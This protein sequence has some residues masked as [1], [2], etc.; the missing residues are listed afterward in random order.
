MFAHLLIASLFCAATPQSR[1]GAG[2]PHA[3]FAMDTSTRDANHQTVEAQLRMVKELGFAG[4]AC[5]APEAGAPTLKLMDALGLKL[6]AIYTGADIDKEPP[7]DPRLPEIIR[8][9]KGRDTLV[10]LFVT[11]QKEKSASPAAD[12]K[13]LAAIRR[14]ADLAAESGL[15]VSIY[16]HN[17]FYVASTRDAVR[18]VPKAERKHLSVTF[19]LCHWLK[20]DG[21]K[22]LDAILKAALPHLSVVT[23]N[24]ADNQ[25]DNWDRLIQPLGSGSYDVYELLV[26]LKRLGFKGSIGLQG[27]G[28]KGDVH[29]HLTQAMAV[30]RDFCR[31][32]WQN[33]G[34]SGSTYRVRYLPELKIE[35]D[36]RSDEPEWSRAELEKH[37]AFPW[38]KSPAPPTEFRALCSRD[39][40]YFAFRLQDPDIFVLEKLRDEEDEVFEDRVEIYFSRDDRLKDYYCAE[41]DSR[42]RLFDYHGSYY[43]QID[44]KWNW[45]KLEAKAAA[46]DGGY[47]VEGRIP[48]AAFES[49][50]FP[51]LEPGV[52]IRCG[53]YRAEFS[54]DSSGRPVEQRET[55]HNRGRRIDGPPPLEEWISW[56]DPKTDEPD[57]HIPASFGWLEIVK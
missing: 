25:G 26:K 53:L 6:F 54:H 42:G 52:K 45:P 19:N 32:L 16:P 2:A 33:A 50:G 24:G 40:L 14:V 5:N 36:G 55:I 38:K 46:I 39:D 1:P 11:S 28:I 10:W 23:I 21:G 56:V 30:W 13:A 37:F 43:R 34:I 49:I 3:F 17:G 51:R 20:V 12:E 22:D 15:G 48:L 31:R 35:L 8:G 4:W 44:P 47:T 41:I 9:L 7:Y 57:F 29:E 18:L 27:Y